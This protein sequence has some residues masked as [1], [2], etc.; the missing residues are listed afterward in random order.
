MAEARKAASK[1][2]TKLLLC[3]GGNGRSGGFSVMVSQVWWDLCWIWCFSWVLKVQLW[4]MVNSQLWWTISENNCIFRWEIKRIGTASWL[5]YLCWWKTTSSME[6]TTIGNILAI[7]LR[8]PD[9]TFI[10][11]IIKDGTWISGR[12]GSVEGLWG[13]GLFAEGD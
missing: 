1:H 4:K 10:I 12:E 3:L 6:S 5:P 13:L 9:W 8:I 11:Y 7:G 2:G